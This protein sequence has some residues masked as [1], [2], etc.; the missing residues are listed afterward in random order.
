MGGQVRLHTLEV[1]MPTVPTLIVAIANI[2]NL[3][4]KAFDFD[5]AFPQVDLEVDV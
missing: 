5:L 2:N 4:A 1:N 3:D